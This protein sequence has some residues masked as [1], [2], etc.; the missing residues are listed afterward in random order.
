VTTYIASNPKPSTSRPNL[1]WNKPDLAAITRAAG[2]NDAA[3]T[4]AQAKIAKAISRVAKV[5]AKA[6]NKSEADA[7]LRD[8][9][10]ALQ[11]GVD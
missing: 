1:P 5:A 9:E 11:G 4:E 8:L 7:G 3:S 2:R 6:A 10:T